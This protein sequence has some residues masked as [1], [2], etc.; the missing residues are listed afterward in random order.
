MKKIKFN[1]FSIVLFAVTLVI[2]FLLGKNPEIARVFYKNGL[3]RLIRNAY[4]FVIGQWLPFPFII[5]AIILLIGGMLYH[6]SFK[7]KLLA[8]LSTGISWILFTLCA[9]YFLWGYN[10]SVAPVAKLIDL[11]IK[12]VDSTALY[13][14][15]NELI[16]H[17]NDFRVTYQNDS[18]PLNYSHNSIEKD[19]RKDLKLAFDQLGIVTAGKPRVRTL[20]P[21]GVLMRFKTAGIYIPHAFEG[22]IDGG[23]LEIEHPFTI[24]HEMSHAYGITGEGD[25]N[26]MAYIACASSD[27]P[28]FKYSAYLDYSL[29]LLRDVYRTNKEKHK[30]FQ[31]LLHPGYKADIRAIIINGDKY[32]DIFPAVRDF[33]YDNYLKSQGIKDGIKNYSRIIQMVI[34]YKRQYPEVL[35]SSP[36]K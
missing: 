22:H 2:Q 29:Y 10:Y 27:D 28:Y 9:F 12:E 20:K 25:C 32:P 5:L 4:D 21:K 17:I 31:T 16:R 36:K 14:E 19:V 6:M 34:N 8:K 15:L 7:K 1:Y 24:A 11:K 30:A 18:L 3:F 33:M 35:G 26:F 13:E 23:L